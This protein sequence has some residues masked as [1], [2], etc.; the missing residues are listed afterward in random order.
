MHAA[1]AK[2]S[3]GCVVLPPTPQLKPPIGAR[4]GLSA[5]T[6]GYGAHAMSLKIGALLSRALG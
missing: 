3:S 5:S 1:A 4:A 2:A 6:A